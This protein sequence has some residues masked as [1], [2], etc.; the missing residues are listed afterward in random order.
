MSSSLVDVQAWMTEYVMSIFLVIGVLGNIINIYMFTIKNFLRNTCCMYLLATSIINVLSLIWGI[1]AALYTVDHIDPSTYS[2]IYCKLR[3]YTIHTLLMIGRSLMVFACID[4]YALCSRSARFRSFCEPKIAIRIIIAHLFIWPLITIHIPILQNLNG[5]SC[6]MSGSY[7][8]IYG[9]YVTICSGTLPP[10]L[11]IIFSVLAIQHRRELRTRLNTTRVNNRRDDTLI[12]MLLSQVIVYVITTCLYPA[13]T[14]YRA[15]TN[16]QTKTSQSLQIETFVNFFSNTILVYLNPAS[17]FYVYFTSSKCF[18]KEC[19]TA[20][21]HLYKKI[22]R[23]R[24]QVAPR[25]I[26]AHINRDTQF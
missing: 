10:V 15:I 11:M 18:R 25:M 24:A 6:G 26:Q 17:A 22:V 23:R 13:I 16:G 2:F 20:F 12:I 8:I 7:I 5:K 14:L 3:L 21:V 9:L 4:R 19:K 1:L